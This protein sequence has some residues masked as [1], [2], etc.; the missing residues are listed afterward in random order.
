[1]KELKARCVGFAAVEQKLR[2][3]DA[4]KATE[5][6]ERATYFDTEGRGALKIVQDESG[7][8]MTLAVYNEE[9]GCFDIVSSPIG[10]V[11]GMRRVLTKLFRRTEQISMDKKVYPLGEVEVWLVHIDRLGNFV[12]IR[13]ENEGPEKL[14]EI[15]NK[16]GLEPEEIVKEDFGELV[17]GAGK[18]IG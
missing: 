13:S 9:D 10:N 4:P 5:V 3:M 1:M 7:G 2:Q 14:H 12:L 6:K 11:E 17:S 15:L 18:K 16:L 8:S